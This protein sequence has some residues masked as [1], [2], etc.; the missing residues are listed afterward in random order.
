MEVDAPVMVKMS[1]VMAWPLRNDKL[2]TVVD[3]GVTKLPHWISPVMST[4]EPDLHE[5]G[6]TRVAR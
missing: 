6:P 4:V 3:A 5:T 1:P 2:V